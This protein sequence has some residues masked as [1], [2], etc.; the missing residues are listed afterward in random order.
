MSSALT[1]YAGEQ[2]LEMN[3]ENI[4]FRKIN[5]IYLIYSTW[6]VTGMLNC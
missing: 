1:R 3:I 2:I 5:S 4:F 6:F